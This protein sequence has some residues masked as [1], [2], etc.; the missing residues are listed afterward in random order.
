MK[1]LHKLDKHA[2]I[3]IVA[4]NNEIPDD[5]KYNEPKKKRHG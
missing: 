1:L 5:E 3:E 4:R 2:V